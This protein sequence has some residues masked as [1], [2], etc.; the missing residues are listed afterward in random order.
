MKKFIPAIVLALSSFGAVA[1]GI[2]SPEAK[3]AYEELSPDA[4]K[5]AALSV[6]TVTDFPA[7][8]TQPKETRR[9][10]VAKDGR[11]LARNREVSPGVVGDLVTAV[12]NYAGIVCTGN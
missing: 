1:A 8:C 9:L 7:F 3:A 4:R 5:L 11:E 2:D 10:A 12:M 6:N